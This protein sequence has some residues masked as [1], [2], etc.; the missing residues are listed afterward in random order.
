MCSMDPISYAGSA[1]TVLS[2]SVTAKGAPEK[3]TLNPA[4]KLGGAECAAK[5]TIV[6]THE[7][8]ESHNENDAKRKGRRGGCRVR[9]GGTAAAEGDGGIPVAPRKGNKVCRRRSDVKEKRARLLLNCSHIFHK[10]VGGRTG[11]GDIILRI[12]EGGG[13]NGSTHLVG[14][15]PLATF[16]KERDGAGLIKHSHTKIVLKNR[17]LY[18][19]KPSKGVRRGVQGAG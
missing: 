4:D 14:R 10:K 6:R 2:A 15:V 19:S 9:E 13:S 11:R 8:A 16:Q 17:E 1:T 7:G 12:G 18:K 3:S 5:S